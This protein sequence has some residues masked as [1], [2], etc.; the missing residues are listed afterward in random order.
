MYINVATLFCHLRSQTRP[1]SMISQDAIKVSA[2][3]QI[4]QM[5]GL[6]RPGPPPAGLLEAIKALLNPIT[7]SPPLIVASLSLL[8]TM[9]R[10]L[11]GCGAHTRAVCAGWGW[12]GGVLAPLLYHP[13]QDVRGASA[14]ALAHVVFDQDLVRARGAR[15]QAVYEQELVVPCSDSNN[16]S[17]E[18]DDVA[19]LA[20]T[21]WRN[22][23]LSGLPCTMYALESPH[24]RCAISFDR[25][26]EVYVAR[27]T[28]VRE[29]HG[30]LGGEDDKSR[31]SINSGSYSPGFGMDADSFVGVAVAKLDEC[32]SHV[33][34]M[35]AVTW[36][37]QLC[38]TDD[39]LASAF[40]SHCDR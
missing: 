30:L 1:M 13:S 31:T 35:S 11:R 9:L 16:R 24:R 36:L 26:I 5:A 3:E 17:F 33:E 38:L 28:E 4:G 34:F 39:R 22:C 8:N 21:A 27:A 15:E 23:L 37:R 32:A 40:L 18:A 25:R 19:F 20:P 12:V 29:N 14:L 6:D 10:P 2:L 7:S